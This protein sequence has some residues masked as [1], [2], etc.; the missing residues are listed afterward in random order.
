MQ[1]ANGSIWKMDTKRR[2]CDKLASFHSGSILALDASPSNHRIVSLGQDATIR[3][4]DNLNKTA[5]G[6]CKY[7]SAGRVVRLHL[8]CRLCFVILTRSMHCVICD[9]SVWI[10]KGRRLWLAFVTVL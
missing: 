4:Y 10:L 6:K 5:L 2:S 8:N 9:G 3:V 1:D 7:S